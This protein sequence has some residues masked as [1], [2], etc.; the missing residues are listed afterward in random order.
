M[1][2]PYA[3]TSNQR[4]APFTHDLFIFT[5]TPSIWLS[6]A[7][8]HDSNNEVSTFTLILL[9]S[10]SSMYNKHNSSQQN[11]KQPRKSL[12]MFNHTKQT[13]HNIQRLS[14]IVNIL[15]KYGF[16]Y[17]IDLLHLDKI[18]IGKK[19]FG[20][21][22]IRGMHVFSLPEEVRLRKVFE[23]LGPTFI[24]LG[25]ILSTRP[26][27]LPTRFHLELEKLQENVAP[28][29]Y[30]KVEKV[31]KHELGKTPEKLFKQFSKEPFAAAS[32]AQAHVAQLPTGEKVVIKI[33]RPGCE[34][35]INADIEILYFFAKLANQYQP[36]LRR[37]DLTGIIDE[38]KST[39][40]REIDFE[41]EA[42]NIRRFQ[43]QFDNDPTIYIPRMYPDFSTKH[44]LTMEKVEGIKITNPANI[45]K[46]QLDGTILANTITR[47]FSRQI[48]IHGFYHA[49]PHPGNLLAR[50]NN[51]IA[52][53]DFGMVGKLHEKT[54]EE[55]AT[56]LVGIV[57]NDTHRIVEGLRGL[58]VIKS[59][60]ENKR[61]E[62]DIEDFVDNY[63]NQPIKNIQLGPCIN[64]LIAIITNHKLTLPSELSVLLRT[65]T[66][67][68]G[69]AA[70]LDPEFN[71]VTMLQPFVKKILKDKYNPQR[72][73]GTVQRSIEA[74]LSL[75]STFPEDITAIFRKIRQGKLHMEMDHKGF[76]P[77][78]H[79]IDAST[80]RV[81]F[82]IIIAAIIIGSS[83]IMHTDKGLLLFG[84]PLLGIIGFLIAALLG[85]WLAVQI[86][87]SGKL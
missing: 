57:N 76:E 16:G 66:T 47:A 72:L 59:E 30:E 20:F 19:V 9:I 54:K 55:I 58:G 83:I 50:K 37:Y 65:L 68:E 41:S 23:E 42:A 52:F 73:M 71:M 2:V 7:S 44:V 75:T 81:S 33:L 86:L 84:F 14:Q 80:N 48:F 18:G 40:L 10:P 78:M 4:T 39:I 11:E 6:G 62:L 45:K 85:L 43:R 21:S 74:V 27:V 35:I 70:N 1:P 22:S 51:V 46:A 82:S 29:P 34:K 56:V 24:K 8:G 38:F 36:E 60:E 12:T 61:L 28:F 17:I 15:A 3:R 69:T 64:N 25:Q 26:D 77:L 13:I 31:I 53:F 67:L 5:K 63:A 79:E 32:L 87:R 49:D